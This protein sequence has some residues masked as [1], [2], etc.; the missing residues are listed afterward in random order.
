MSKIGSGRSTA[1]RIQ[2]PG[3]KSLT[4]RAL[5]AAALAGGRVSLQNGLVCDDTR[6]TMDALQAWG[7]SVWVSGKEMTVTGNGGK[8]APRSTVGVMDIGNSGTSLRLLL[9]VAALVPG[10]WTFSGNV[11][12]QQRPIAPLVE[13]LNHMGVAAGCQENGCPPVWVQGGGLPG[14]R[15][16]IRG[17]ES[18][19]FVSAL[20]LSGPYAETDMAI[21]VVGDVVSRP[22]VDMTMDMM[23][24]FGVE[25]TRGEGNR[26]HVSSGQAYRPG[27]YTIPGDASSASYFWARA[28]VTGGTVVTENVDAVSPVQGDARFLDILERMGCTVRRRS[29]GPGG[30]ACRI[31]CVHG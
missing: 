27:A 17:D 20:L 16:R 19:Q 6:R 12:M 4:H 24:T 7:S 22:Y 25:V 3:S 18:S 9:P 26:F 21:E 2:V 11:R 1:A 28:A 29:H 15:V 5:I 30:E 8:F 14:G 10:Q 23:Q 13:A 31:G